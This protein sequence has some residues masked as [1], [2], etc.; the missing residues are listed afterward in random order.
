MFRRQ[1]LLFMLAASVIVVTVAASS[2]TQGRRQQP[3]RDTSAQR[4][5]DSTPP[6][7]GRITG[8]VLTADT[9]RPVR[10]ARVFIN[11]AE[12]PAARGTSTDDNCGFELDCL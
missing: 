11:A 3:A 10:L 2:Q 8:R 12:M 9:G 1:P 7:K 6:A 5:D 4:P